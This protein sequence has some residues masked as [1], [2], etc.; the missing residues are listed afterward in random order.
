MLAI[1]LHLPYIRNAFTTI[2]GSNELS[3]VTGFTQ[4]NYEDFY[5]ASK[6][7]PSDQHLLQRL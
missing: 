1:K 5:M 3:A 4:R 7:I 2:K 6:H